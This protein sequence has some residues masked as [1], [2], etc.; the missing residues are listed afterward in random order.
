[1]ARRRA[2]TKI[3]FSA[4]PLL[5][6]RIGVV[7]VT[8]PLPVARVVVGR[9]ANAGQPLRALPE[10]AV[11]HDGAHR[12]AVPARER[13]ALLLVRDEDV[14]LERLLDVDVRSVVRGALEDRE[15]RARL[16]LGARRQVG[17]TDAGPVRADDAPLGHAVDVAGLLLLRHRQELG[18]IDLER[19]FDLAVDLGAPVLR[20]RVAF[21]PAH[22]TEALERVLIGGKARPSIGTELLHELRGLLR[23][24]EAIAHAADEHE[25]R[26]GERAE[27]RTPVRMV[28]HTVVYDARA[29]S[30]STEG[31]RAALPLGSGPA[32]KCP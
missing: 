16:E 29:N 9:E 24:G 11:G 20:A 12:G 21:G 17:D 19:R 5:E 2:R 31:D 7:V 3:F 18:V 25:R 13:L 15:A 30:V 28:S 27:E 8:A 32:A 1:M 6:P 10:I 23:V 26:A 22:R 4:I 14:G